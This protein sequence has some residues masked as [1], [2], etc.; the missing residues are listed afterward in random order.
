M[1]ARVLGKER[2]HAPRLRRADGSRVQRAVGT[3]RIH[4]HR[5]RDAP[6]DLRVDNVGPVSLNADQG[7]ARR[8]V[9]GVKRIVATSPGRVFHH[10]IARF[11]T[12]RRIDLG[13]ADSQP[14]V[15]GKQHREIGRIHLREIPQDVNQPAQPS[16]NGKVHPFPHDRLRLRIA[17]DVSA[18]VQDLDQPHPCRI[19]SLDHV[20]RVV[21]MALV[22]FVALERRPSR[23]SE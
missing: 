12:G 18:V 17:F 20:H 4:A 9:E 1:C 23:K 10:F 7:R 5:R 16:R 22:H 21:V 19:E 13:E 15:S 3:P 11:R 2:R 8:F 6:F 14:A